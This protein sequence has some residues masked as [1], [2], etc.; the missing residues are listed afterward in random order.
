MDMLIEFISST[1]F[2]SAVAVQKS[3]IKTYA[4]TYKPL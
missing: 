4:K 1:V 3:A 2:L